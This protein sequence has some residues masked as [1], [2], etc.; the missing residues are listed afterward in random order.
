MQAVLGLGA[1]G[2]VAWS[3]DGALLAVGDTAGV[4]IYDAE[5]LTLKQT[6]E[7]KD[8]SGWGVSKL[9]FSPDGKLILVGW[10]DQLR[11]YVLKNE[12]TWPLSP[13]ISMDSLADVAFSPDS[14]WVAVTIRY[15][16]RYFASNSVVVLDALTGRIKYELVQ[17]ESAEV[18]AM[19]FSSDGRWIAIAGDDRRVRLWDMTDGSLSAELTGHT[20]AVLGLAFAP[21]GSALVSGGADGALRIWEVGSW[22]LTRTAQGFTQPIDRLQFA[23]NGE[24]LLVATDGHLQ[25]RH[26]P[27]LEVEADLAGV[28]S[29]VHISPDGRR[30]VDRLIVRD[31][32]T[33]QPG[34]SLP[35]YIDSIQYLDFNQ[36]GSTLAVGGYGSL[37]VW[38]VAGQRVIINEAFPKHIVVPLFDQTGSTLVTLLTR[39]PEIIL[40][41]MTQA[42]QASRWR[43]GPDD[44]GTPTLA[45]S[46]HLLLLARRGTV[47][48]LQIW[49]L[50]THTLTHE[51]PWYASVLPETLF[52]DADRQALVAH[53]RSGKEY[54]YDLA[55]GTRQLSRTWSLHTTDTYSR[56][57]LSADADR[58]AVVVENIP[59]KGLV[60][61]WD[62]RT[63]Q[64][65]LSRSSQD[66]N[67]S[68]P[69]MAFTH[70]GDW[71]VTGSMTGL[72]FFNT[73][74]P[75]L[76]TSIE[77]DGEELINGVLSPDDSR[78]A[79]STGDSRVVV[80]DLAALKVLAAGASTQDP[81]VSVAFVTAL[82]TFTAAPDL[83]LT[84]L[85]VAKAPN[86]AITASSVVSL[87]EMTVLGGGTIRAASL[88]RD[89]RQVAIAGSLGVYIY[90]AV[91]LTQVAFLPT[92]YS[93]GQV[94]FSADGFQVAAG[95]GQESEPMAWDIQAESQV[96]AAPACL[97]Q[98]E[99]RGGLYGQRDPLG[100]LT[101]R[102][103]GSDEI[104]AA[105]GPFYN[106]VAGFALSADGRLVAI[107]AEGQVQVIDLETDDVLWTFSVATFDD[108]ISG[109]PNQVSRLAFSSDGARLAASSEL[110]DIWVLSVSTGAVEAQWW[111]HNGS[112]MG[113]FFD[114]SG[115]R[116]FTAGSDGAA[117]VWESRT[118]QRL[119]DRNVFSRATVVG[120]AFL[121][122]GQVLSTDGDEIKRWDSSTGSLLQV[123]AVQSGTI[124]VFAPDASSVIVKRAPTAFELWSLSPFQRTLSVVGEMQAMYLSG[125]DLTN[126]GHFAISPD[127][128]LIA[129]AGIDPAIRIWDAQTGAERLALEPGSNFVDGIAF[130]PDGH[131]LVAIRSGWANPVVLV[132]ETATGRPRREFALT[133]GSDPKAVAFSPD[134]LSLAIVD[135]VVQIYDLATSRPLN[136]LD[137]PARVLAYSPDGSLLA[138][139]D[140][141]GQVQFWDVA[142]GRIIYRMSA[143]TAEI[144]RIMFVNQGRT[145][146]TA[147]GDGTVRVWSAAK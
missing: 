95:F 131:W 30:F 63:D 103:S 80:W 86:S 28:D 111:A 147:G 37:W 100:G 143:H 76:S 60:Q 113:L 13:D 58:L 66:A 81:S 62:A 23:T 65:L 68:T 99:V 8:L 10:Y 73:H 141:L 87:T 51:F 84:P 56:S 7:V 120:M 121:G 34:G 54:V 70:D 72:R 90:R 128:S 44:F 1:A 75:T 146:L 136:V 46:G 55:T 27:S 77:W 132:F 137:I 122:S 124:G 127:G 93:V 47:N 112:L 78:L 116:L 59:D 41:D 52:L 118:G 89:G 97:A 6:I 24:R 129:T 107:A 16:S 140:E 48:R 117:R 96:D 91:D 45:A 26:W 22:A 88:S 64:L 92:D 144:T 101:I 110:G 133:S 109:Y 83:A 61:I 105:F 39:D 106:A 108:E 31:A 5:H 42:R 123:T 53:S 38:D 50:D 36:D 43:I 3:S 32:Q 57:L 69:L 135:E 19:T 33:G 125:Q 12:A 35:P 2:T 138:I 18:N 74:D 49:D 139:G 102:A 25:T 145:L 126:Y 94:C 71:L 14:K 11:I 134:G 67:L 79:V 104:T 115:A 130:S 17:D 40:W 20:H 9:A 4:D 82:P 114:P 15:R 21:D 98:N 85:P 29:A 119:V 142:S